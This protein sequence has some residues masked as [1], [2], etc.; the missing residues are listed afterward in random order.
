MEEAASLKSIPGDAEAVRSENIER[1]DSEEEAAI[2][3]LLVVYL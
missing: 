1:G 3:V 2:G